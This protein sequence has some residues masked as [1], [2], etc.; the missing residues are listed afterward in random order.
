MDKSTPAKH[1]QFTDKMTDTPQ[2]IKDL[3]LKIWLSK[4]PMERLH[5]FMTDNEALL[6]F[7]AVTKIKNEFPPKK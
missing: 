2:E 7:W 6:K 4:P 1:F 3:Q 5:Q